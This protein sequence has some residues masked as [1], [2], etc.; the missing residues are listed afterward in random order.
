MC[1]ARRWKRIDM[2]RNLCNNMASDGVD[3]ELTRK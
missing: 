2:V 1:T 3:N